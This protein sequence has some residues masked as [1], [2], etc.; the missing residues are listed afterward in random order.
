[1][2]LIRLMFQQS[3][4]LSSLAIAVGAI[5][6]A[7][8]AGLIATVNY[9]LQNVDRA[10]AI[11]SVVAFTGLCTLLLGTTVGSQILLARLSQDLVLNLRVGLVR[12]ILASPLERLEKVGIPRLLSA[13][14]EDVQT[15][16]VA[17]IAIPGICLNLA[18]L[19]SC[20]VYLGWLSLS[21]LAFLVVFA[22][23]GIGLFFLPFSRGLKLFGLV[24]EA[25]DRL[26]EN[27]QAATSGIKELQ[28]NRNRRAAFLTEELDA[29][30]TDLRDR[31]IQGVS[32]MS[33]SSSLTLVLL[34]IPIGLLLLGLP[35]VRPVASAEL[36]SYAFAILFLVNPLRSLL[37]SAPQ[38]S[39]AGIA[40]EKIESLGL[41]GSDREEKHLASVAIASNPQWSS[42]EF[43]EV[44]YTYY[45]DEKKLF[46]IVPGSLKFVPGEITFIIGPNGSGK[47]T[48]LKLLS[49]LY[50]PEAGT[51]RLDGQAI[52]DDNRDWYRQHFSAIFTDFYLF[53]RLLGLEGEDLDVRAQQYLS[54]LQLERKVQVRDGRLSTLHLSQGQRKR[55][56]LLTAYLEDRPIYVFDEWAADQDPEF[57][58]LFYKQM[59]PAL[60]ERG[61]TAIVVSHDDRYFAL[62]DRRIKLP[63]FAVESPSDR[64]G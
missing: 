36:S 46:T 6:G 45:D 54:A 25:T 40:F 3:W 21:V 30:A 16:A 17:A 28:L 22:I 15:I 60:K 10:L 39:R 8:S 13:L 59:L 44:R 20:M 18:I 55:L 58:D 35:R 51:I 64:C 61:K 7:S 57:K 27:Y 14:T 56:A 37:Q 32:L 26:F 38:V 19:V 12:Q 47:S 62:A 52:A 53:D 42:I 48:L 34:F 5:G 11:E 4:L 41:D 31:W 29:S 2:Q 43:E 33:L 1:M 63:E 49:G 23:V 50:V 24:R 9:I